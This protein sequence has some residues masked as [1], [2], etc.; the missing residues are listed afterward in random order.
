VKIAGV[1]GVAFGGVF[2]A[3]RV[4]DLT[5]VTVVV[6]VCVAIIIVTAGVITYRL[7]SSKGVA[8]KVRVGD[9]TLEFERVKADETGTSSDDDGA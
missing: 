4:T 3:G 2:A 6:S 7:I 8:P 5:L 9:A 1:I